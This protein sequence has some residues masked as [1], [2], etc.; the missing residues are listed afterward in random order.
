VVYEYNLLKNNEHNNAIFFILS[1][2][3]SGNNS[4]FDHVKFLIHKDEAYNMDK[5][6]IHYKNMCGGQ[7][8]NMSIKLIQLILI[9]RTIFKYLEY[10]PEGC[11]YYQSNDMPFNA[12][13]HTLCV[14]KCL[15]NISMKLLHC[16][17]DAIDI[18]FHHDNYN[19]DSVLICN[20]REREFN[21]SFYKYIENKCLKIC[22]KDCYFV[23]YYWDLK[24]IE[25][26]ITNQSLNVTKNIFL[27]STIILKWDE[28]SPVYEYEEQ[29]VLSFTDYL[30]YCGGLFGLWFGTNA[31]D[32]I[33]WLIE[34]PFCL[35]FWI[36]LKII[37]KIT[38]QLIFQL[39]INICIKFNNLYKNLII[40]V[41]MCKCKTNAP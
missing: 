21:F 11:S 12:S 29:C 39:I 36:K 31:K 19:N 2:S 18:S 32:F 30:C 14:N 40:F 24:P 34:R 8:F 4:K 38:F 22:P 1:G 5:T 13:S 37:T 15:I 41:K 3:C 35:L 17:S 25:Y 28:N 20:P 7:I 23:E 26:Q 10:T 9:R 33:I 6:K 27:N 16:V